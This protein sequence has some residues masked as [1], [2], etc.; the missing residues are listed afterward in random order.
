MARTAIKIGEDVVVTALIVIVVLVGWRY[1]QALLN[2]GGNGNGSGTDSNGNAVGIPNLLGPHGTVNL[3]PIPGL[4]DQT[5][6]TDNYAYDE[7]NY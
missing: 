3:P 4:L 2:G 6:Y 7:G 1:V 5:G